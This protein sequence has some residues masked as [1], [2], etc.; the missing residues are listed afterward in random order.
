MAHNSLAHACPHTAT[1]E[2][3]TRDTRYLAC[4][5]A[6]GAP[7]VWARRFDGIVNPAFHSER[8][9]T[10]PAPVVLDPEARKSF[11]EAVLAT[12]LV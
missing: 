2:E 3:R 1:T 8:L 4:N 7:C 6:P 10:S 11:D 12:G 5:A 9:E